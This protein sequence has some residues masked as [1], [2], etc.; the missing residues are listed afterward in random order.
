[1]NGRSWDDLDKETYEGFI[2]YG[3][4]DIFSLAELYVKVEN[5]MDEMSFKLFEQFNKEEEEYEKIN[6]LNILTIGSFVYGNM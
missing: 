3:M 4:Y 1:M 5:I 2:E 6:I